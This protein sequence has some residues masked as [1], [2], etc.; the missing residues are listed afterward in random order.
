MKMKERASG[1]LLKKLKGFKSKALK[2]DRKLKSSRFNIGKF[3]I[4]GFW[5]F[6]GI[7]FL[8]SYL[9]FTRVGFLNSKINGYQAE[10]K[11]KIESLN[12]SGFITSPAAE[13][14]AERFI[15]EYIAIPAESKQ[16]EER[17]ERIAAYLA[18]GLRLDDMEDIKGF[19]GKR[20]LN[21][22]QLH[23]FKDVKKNTAT[24][25]Y[26]V[27]YSS[28]PIVQEVVKEKE[29]KG[30]KSKTVEKTVFKEKTAVRNGVIIAVPI[31]T[32][33][34]SFNVIEQPYMR[35]LPQETKLVAVTNDDSESERN[36]KD[37][38]A[39]KEFTAEFLTSLTQNSVKE[40]GYLMDQPESLEGVYE[41]QGINKF[42]LY[43]GSE[44]AYEIKA[45]IDFK[46]V[47]SGIVTRQPLTMTVT[48]DNGKYF[49]KK[50]KH[51]IG[52]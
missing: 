22:I 15:K 46:E 18:E 37:E 14:Y 49:V 5:G 12:E 7:V 16:R 29:G 8:M 20:V 28:V 39:L 30:K 19:Q 33:G 9:S 24:I 21:D 1:A 52:G 32:D 23:S 42:T 10:A 47:S 38:A 48:N 11:E 4:I 40:M 2:D 17:S 31:A 25:L 43:N 26:R 36:Y 44:G 6:V 41:Y 34:A 51:T 27:D 13:D 50:I 35:Q 45:Y 3:I